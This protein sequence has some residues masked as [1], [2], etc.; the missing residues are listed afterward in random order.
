MDFQEVLQTIW[1]VLN[2]PAGVAALAGL[3]LYALNRF[4]AK[5]PTWQE[6]EGTIVAAVKFAEKHIPDGT[7]NQSLTR[8][9]HALRYALKIFEEVESRRPTAK[10]A[11]SLREGIQIVHAELEASGNLTK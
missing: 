11:S 4:Y 8:L 9:D 1:A 3:L 10:E 5:N 6:Y 2:S 7:E